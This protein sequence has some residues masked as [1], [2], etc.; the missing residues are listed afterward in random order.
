MSEAHGRAVAFALLP[1]ERSE[2]KASHALLLSV[3]PL[4]RVQRVICDRGYSSAL[5]RAAIR[6]VGAEAV[7]PAPRS[8]PQVDYDRA[9][10]R[11]RHRVEQ[12]WGRLKE[13]RA[14]ATR[15]E[16]TASSYLGVLYVAA[17]M[18]WIKSLT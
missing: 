16:K 13:W 10:Y 17:A 9:A 4:G 14:V 8:H 6:L 1:G 7:V 11:R 5:W 18:D 15:Y 3:V 2:L 12:V